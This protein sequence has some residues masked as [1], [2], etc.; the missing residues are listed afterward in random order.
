MSTH[1]W[2]WQSII[3]N[4]MF[5]KEWDELCNVAQA[6]MKENAYE[7]MHFSLGEL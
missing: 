3:T 4:S 6:K 1:R 7:L 5:Q 2:R